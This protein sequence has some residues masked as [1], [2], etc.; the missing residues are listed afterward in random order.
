MTTHQAVVTAMRLTDV[1]AIVMVVVTITVGT[2]C[3]VGPDY[4]RTSDAAVPKTFADALASDTD[5]D[6]AQLDSLWASMQ[7]AELDSLIST[8]LE[9]NTTISIAAATLDETRALSGLTLYSWFPTA[10][11][12]AESER[13]QQSREDPFA[14]PGP[15][16]T[17]R[18]RS[19]FDVNWEIDLFGSLRRQSEQIYRLVEADEAELAAARLSVTAEVAQTYFQWRGD[20]H[21]FDVL[22]RNLTNQQR[23]V[24]ILEDSLRAGR[25]TALDVARAQAV[26]RSVAAR[27][28]QAEAA[29]ARAEQRLSVLTGLSVTELSQTLLARQPLPGLPRLIAVGEPL[30]WFARRPDIRAAERRLAAATSDVGV[31]TAQF[32]PVLTLLGDFGWNGR[33]EAA[34][35]NAAAERWRV[36]P[37][38]SWRL[39]DYGRIRQRVVA[40][41]ARVDSAMATYEATWRLALEETENAL[42]AY[43]AVTR[44]EAALIAATGHSRRAAELARLRFDAGADSY[45][46]VL[47]A[48]RSLIEF[49]DQLATVST[50]RATALV[51]LYKAFAG[52]FAVNVASR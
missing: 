35:G 23:N 49:E 11:F 46:A 45:L 13:N 33:S 14:F 41:E 27:L 38:L 12:L 39:P 15:A 7:L 50:D 3:T 36:A 1:R 2:G 42:T 48:E 22:Q 26:E 8:A 32:F 4:V 21:R 18:F 10:G 47:D 20:Q 30:D 40:A 19:G 43:R 44:E 37:S 6:G 5:R 25:G 9:R 34:F 24:E 31:Q 51:G 29:I 16:I 52:D 17:E 28:P